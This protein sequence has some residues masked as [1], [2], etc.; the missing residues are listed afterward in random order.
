M[1][2]DNGAAVAHDDADALLHFG[3]AVCEEIYTEGW[4]EQPAVSKM[5]TDVADA[6]PQRAQLIVTTARCA[7][8]PEAT[9]PI[10][11]RP[12]L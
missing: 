7:R 11:L 2:A 10:N 6:S 1:L 3:Y 5:V 4:S 9:S 8:M 12:R